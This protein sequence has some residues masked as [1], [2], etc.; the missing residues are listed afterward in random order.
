M[1]QVNE[2]VGT[3]MNGSMKAVL[4]S[5]MASMSLASMLFQPRMLEP[6]KPRP[7][8]KASSLSSRIGILKCCHVPKVSTNL[9]STIRAFCFFANSNTL[10][11]VLMY[12]RFV[13][14]PDKNSLQQ[15]SE[16]KLKIFLKERIDA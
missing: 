1:V 7:S 8:L 4:G 12:V 16:Q 9:I 6:S 13:F 15:L 10:F 2:R 14:V 3:A 11:G 5:G